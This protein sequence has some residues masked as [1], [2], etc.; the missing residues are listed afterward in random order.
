MDACKQA[1]KVADE[2]EVPSTGETN[3]A[4]C[5]CCAATTSPSTGETAHCTCGCVQ[6]AS[7]E[8]SDAPLVPRPQAYSSSTSCFGGSGTVFKLAEVQRHTHEEDCWLIA[9]G[10]VYDATDFIDV[11][12]GGRS[13]IIRRAGGDATRDFD[14]HSKSARSSWKQFQIGRLEKK[15]SCSMM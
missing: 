10:N 12:P 13:S 7:G 9:H 14:F 4:R 2:V 3:L 5:L 6:A 15:D 11:H 1:S 8:T